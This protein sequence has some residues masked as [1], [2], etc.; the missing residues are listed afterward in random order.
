RVGAACRVLHEQVGDGGQDDP[1]LGPVAAGQEAGQ[2]GAVA[3]LG[4]DGPGP[5]RGGQAAAV[6]DE[7]SH[8]PNEQG[9]PSGL[10]AGG[11]QEGLDP[12]GGGGE[13]HGGAPFAG[14]G[15]GWEPAT[16]PADRAAQ[17]RL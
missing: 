7:G 14:D 2:L 12:G 8:Q 5:L 11:P 13:D 15:R 6:A 4:A 1:V 9:G 16:Y 3:G 10:E 17:R